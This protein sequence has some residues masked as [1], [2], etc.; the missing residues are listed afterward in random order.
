MDDALSSSSWRRAMEEELQA[1]AQDH[2]WDLVP[3]PQG[4]HV[5][6]NRWV[7]AVKEHSDGL[8]ER[9]KARMVAK[10]FTQKYGIDCQETFAPVA[11]MNTVHL[12]LALVA[13][14]GW[15]LQ[16]YDVKNTFVH[17]DLT[18]EIYMTLPPGYFFLVPS[19]PASVVCRLR[20]S[21]YGLKQ[22]PR[23]WF[24]RFTTAMRN[25]GYQQCNGE[26]TLFYRHSPSGGV[27]ILLV[28]VDAI[29]ITG[30]DNLAIAEL[31]S[32]LASEFA[33]KHLG[34]LRYFLGIEV[35]YSSNGL[36]IC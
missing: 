28:Y 16:Q 3:L 30:D 18:E 27:V 21:L 8:L 31:A 12:L 32:Y 34:L 6:G 5:V 14:R 10:G 23:A 2:T 4:K 1:L 25:C 26:H 36:F 15:I 11:K 9:Y 33:I 7:Y 35:A 19:T 17:G 29:I 13:H 24:A 22:S 20:K